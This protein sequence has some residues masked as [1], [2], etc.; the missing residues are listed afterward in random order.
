MKSCLAFD[1]GATA[2]RAGLYDEAGRLL[3]ERTGAPANPVAYG[4]AGCVGAL[5][6]LGGELLRESDVAPDVVAAG[7]SGAAS[8]AIRAQVASALHA[9]FEPERTLVTGDLHALMLANAGTDPAIFVIAGTGSSVIAQDDT[10][11]MAIAGGYGTLMGDEGGACGVALR[12]LRAAA[13]AEDG[14]AAPTALRQVLMDAAGVEAFRELCGWTERADKSEVAALAMVVADCAEAGDET[15]LQCLAEGARLMARQVAA[16]RDRLL[17]PESVRLIRHGGMLNNARYARL[18][19]EFLVESGLKSRP[20][21]PEFSGHQAVARLAELAVPPDAVTVIDGTVARD[22][23]LAPTE[24]APAGEAPIDSLTARELVLRM[25]QVQESVGSAVVQ[26]ADALAAVIERVADAISA[27]GRLVYVGAGTSGRLGVLDASECPP[28]FGVEA[29]RVLGVIAGG[30]RALRES[31][32][33]SEDDEKQAA[34]DLDG[35]DPP[36]GAADVVIGIAASGTTP[37]VRG[38]LTFARSAGCYTALLSCNPL[39]ETACDAHI[40]LNTGPELLPGST[41][42]K[43]GTATKLALNIISTGAMTRAGFVF[44]GRMVGM[45]PV[46]RKLRARA[47]RIVAELT[48][49]DDPAALLASAGDSIRVAVLMGRRGCSVEEAAARLD[50]SGGNLRDALALD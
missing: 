38:A 3:I 19:E 16:A 40:A 39:S 44:E 25:A 4:I 34:A 13:Q 37:Y 49:T 5:I 31:V 22:S 14:L 6:G 47:E 2:T 28:T 10:G 7:V 15:A 42:L 48:G 17:L 32:E 46:N 29:D 12:A 41:R 45:H 43:A 24:R 1:A 18:F 20:S 9:H 21:P 26:Q 27:S 8:P 50:Q 11:E 33:G 35:L 30:E 36:L 23:D